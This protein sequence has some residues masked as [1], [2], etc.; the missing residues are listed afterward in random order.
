MTSSGCRSCT[1]HQWLR[2]RILQGLGGDCCCLGL[3]LLP[4]FFF[5]GGG[6][7][8]R[9]PT[10]QIHLVTV[11]SASVVQAWPAKASMAPSRAVC[12]RY[13]FVHLR[14]YN[15]PNKPITQA[16]AASCVSRPSG[17]GATA[18]Y[19]LGSLK[20]GLTINNTAS[21]P[22]PANIGKEALSNP[23]RS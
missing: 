22:P 3:M 10:S 15:L 4:L 14:S 20:F 13:T 1:S 12:L 6:V 19:K 9:I 8:L 11:H 16:S 17:N 2:M 21:P 18:E 23:G 7:I 5:G